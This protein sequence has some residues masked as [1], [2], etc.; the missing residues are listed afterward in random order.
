M[1]RSL[2]TSSADNTPRVVP[3]MLNVLGRSKGKK[4]GYT[5]CCADSYRGV[6][7]GHGHKANTH[8]L[9]THDE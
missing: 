2:P 8:L 9:Q 1:A 6:L 3:M 7:R 5:M 4:Y